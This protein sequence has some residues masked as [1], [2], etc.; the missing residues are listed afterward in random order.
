MAEDTNAEI[1]EGT[2]LP[3]PANSMETA[4]VAEVEAIGYE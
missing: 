4:D 3:D 2:E 1:P